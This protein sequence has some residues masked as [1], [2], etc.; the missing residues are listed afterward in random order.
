MSEIT[1][2]DAT[3]PRYCDRAG[4]VERCRSTP[5]ELERAFCAPW[6]LRKTPIRFTKPASVG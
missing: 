5:S 1:T 2:V 6:R 4:G 3:A